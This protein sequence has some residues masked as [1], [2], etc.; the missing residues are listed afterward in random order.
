LD[1]RRQSSKP[2]VKTARFFVI[3][4]AQFF[5]R[6]VSKGKTVHVNR[7]VRNSASGYV[8]EG[9]VR[10]EARA[11]TPINLV[12]LRSSTR[13]QLQSPCPVPNATNRDF[14]DVF[15]VQTTSPRRSSAAI[16]RSSMRRKYPDPRQGSEQ[17]DAWDLVMACVFR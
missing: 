1:Q 2:A 17:L 13:R 8:L 16:E 4:A 3:V 11:L 6:S 5:V 7:S 10:Q 14:S 15:A 12:N 9:S